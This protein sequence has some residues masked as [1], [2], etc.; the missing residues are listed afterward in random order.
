LI[1]CLDDL[2]IG[3]KGVFKSP[4]ATVLDFIYVFRSFRVCLMKLGALTLDAYRLIIVISFWCI[5]PVISMECPSLS[6]LINVGLKS[7]L[8]EI[9]IAPPACFQGPLAW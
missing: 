7:T 9:S 8:S 3:D 1:F 2:S 5:S 4:T 6:C